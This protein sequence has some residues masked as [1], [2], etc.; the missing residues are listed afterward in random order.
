MTG[1]ALVGFAMAIAR[2]ADARSF[3]LAADAGAAA[4][5]VGLFAYRSGGRS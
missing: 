2:R 5:V 4:F 3:E 1:V